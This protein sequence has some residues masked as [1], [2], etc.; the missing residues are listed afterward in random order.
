MP[1]HL[2]FIIGAHKINIILDSQCP[3]GKISDHFGTFCEH[4]AQDG[5]SEETFSICLTFSHG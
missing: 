1:S 3:V 5:L 2:N 4:M